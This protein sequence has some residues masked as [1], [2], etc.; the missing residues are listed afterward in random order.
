[1]NKL[2]KTMK[3]FG[4][5]SP[6]DKQAFLNELKETDT[7]EKSVEETQND[8]KETDKVGST[9]NVSKEESKVEETP[10]NVE[11]TETKEVEQTQPEENKVETEATDNA[12][13][14]TEEENADQIVVGEEVG[15]K[16]V[17]EGRDINDF[18]TKDD[19]QKLLDQMQ[20]K[21]DEKDNI[22]KGLQEQVEKATND[23]QALENKYEKE[24]F[25]EFYQ[26]F[27][28][29]NS[30]PKQESISFKDFFNQNLKK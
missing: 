2:V 12:D 8:L 24:S 21:M 17:A 30:E 29:S 10:K 4:D 26:R 6:E 28:P 14:H 15:D 3:L 25:G 23:K 1:M 20:A 7:E 16:Y 5:L 19:L 9:E 18:V 22:I 11:T 13:K 27:N